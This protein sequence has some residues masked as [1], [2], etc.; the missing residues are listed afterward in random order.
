MKHIIYKITNT[1]NNKIYVG[2]HST[3]DINDSYMGS[4]IAIKKAQKKYGMK[5]FIK[6]ILHVFDTREE[7][8]EKEREIV[9][10]EFINRPDTYNAGIG[11]KGAPMA[12][13]GWSDEQRKLI[14]EN[15]SKV[16]QS[17]EMRE[18]LSKIKKGRKQSQESNRKRSETLKA[19]YMNGR[20]DREYKPL[21]EAHKAKLGRSVS[22][23]GVVYSSGSEAAKSLSMSHSGLK[24]R[25]NSDKYPTWKFVA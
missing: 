20:I 16:M 24:Y 3:E 5:H 11:G 23:D 25:I 10:I 13:I 19:K 21:T 12:L 4:G 8:Y 17:P 2:A 6:E 22:I 15:T 9:D 14:S 7:M 18:R 1:I